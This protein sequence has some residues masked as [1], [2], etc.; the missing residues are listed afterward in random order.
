MLISKSIG[1]E[2]SQPKYF[3]NIFERGIDP[4]VD[5]PDHCHVSNTFSLPFF[6]LTMTNVSRIIQRFQRKMKTGQVLELL[7]FFAMRSAPD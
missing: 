3:W 4:H 7:S 6:L 1:G 2:P 5:D